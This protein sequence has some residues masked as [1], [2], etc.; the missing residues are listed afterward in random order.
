M[1]EHKETRVEEMR[2]YMNIVKGWVNS[3]KEGVE[4][5]SALETSDKSKVT[6]VF[7]KKI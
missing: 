4:V 2:R 6:V 5:E 3:L 1:S 7:R